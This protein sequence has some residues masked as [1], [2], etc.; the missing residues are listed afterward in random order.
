MNFARV[1]AQGTEH[2]DWQQGSDCTP[3]TKYEAGGWG[4]NPYVL[5]GGECHLTLHLGACINTT[6][7]LSTL[8][9][10]SLS[11]LFQEIRR[12]RLHP[13]C[14]PRGKMPRLGTGGYM[15]KI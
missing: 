1:R 13:V 11:L 7:Y 4:Q 9:F 2:R 6:F 8:S 10:Y 12:L 5:R 14:T 15:I 3:F